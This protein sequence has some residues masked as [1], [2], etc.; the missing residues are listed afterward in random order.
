MLRSAN[1]F[2]NGAGVILKRPCHSCITSI[3]DKAIVNP[4]CPRNVTADKKILFFLHFSVIAVQDNNSIIGSYQRFIN[5]ATVN[6]FSA[7]DS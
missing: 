2:Y 3:F 5:A 4:K 7:K 1:F 6:R